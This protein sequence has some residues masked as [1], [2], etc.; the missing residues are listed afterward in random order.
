MALAANTISKEAN[1]E[2]YLLSPGL[3][4]NRASFPL[5]RFNRSAYILWRQVRQILSTEWCGGKAWVE[6]ES[7][8]E[9][10]TTLP[11]AIKRAL[12]DT[13]AQDED[14]GQAKV[15][16]DEEDEQAE[17]DSGRQ[18]GKERQTQEGIEGEGVRRREHNSTNNDKKVYYFHSQLLTAL[19][20][21]TKCTT[22][23]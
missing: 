8:M 16:C 14:R 6:W 5:R 15:Q 7:M 18:E 19:R 2:P 3:V 10:Y 22:W 12:L 4:R 21:V 20:L 11:D 1:S 23:P 9:V 13:V 17:H